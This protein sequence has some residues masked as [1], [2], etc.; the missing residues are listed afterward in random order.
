M[1]IIEQF[2]QSKSGRSN[3]NEDRIFVNNDFACV[4]D[5]GTSQSDLTWEGEA[6]GQYAANLICDTIGS[7]HKSISKSEAISHISNAFL[8]A[9][10]KNDRYDYVKNQTVHRF[11]ASF[12]LFSRHH[13]EVWLVGDC[14]CRV[15]GVVYQN[16]GILEELLSNIRTLFLEIELLSG[17]TIRELQEYDT[18]R[19]YIT[20]LLQNVG[21]FRNI[22]DSKF[23]FSAIDGF[24]VNEELTSSI[25]IDPNETFLVLASDG[26]PKLM[27]TLQESE[28]V[29]IEILRADPLMMR[30]HPSTKGLYKSNVSYD[31][32]AYL[33]IHV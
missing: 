25:K 9:Y 27:S 26:Y 20:P 4:V 28:N 24:K 6:P 21:L 11:F 18:S 14:Q 30:E 15:G 10:K 16:H 32:R 5:G 1:K 2:L 33:R 31:D 8:M 29:L 22:N 17:K 3:E 7:F 23:A 12:A 19:E 13:S